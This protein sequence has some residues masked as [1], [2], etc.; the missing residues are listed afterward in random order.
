LSLF[1]VFGL[2]IDGVLLGLYGPVFGASA[3]SLIVGA[4]L[5]AILLWGYGLY[6]VWRKTFGR[7]REGLRAEEAKHFRAGLVHY[8]GENLDE[9]TREFLFV[10]RLDDEDIDALF[11]LAMTHQ[12][13][14]RYPH[15]RRLFRKCQALDVWG[16]WTDEIGQQLSPA[17]SR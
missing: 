15:A 6:D 17:S 4:G 13:A 11:Y 14:G 16:K 8:L 1:A 7:L 2:A 5:F 9:A 12:R 10:L 3:D